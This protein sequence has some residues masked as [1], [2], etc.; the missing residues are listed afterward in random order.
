M[1][2]EPVPIQPS[3]FPTIWKSKNPT[4]LSAD[5]ALPTARRPL[6]R[7]GMMW[8]AINGIHGEL[9]NDDKVTVAVVAPAVRAA[10][11]EEFGLS[12]EFATD[13]RFVS[14]LKSV[15]FDYVFDVDFAADLTIMEESNELLARLQQPDKY[16]WPMFTSCCPAGSAL[17]RASIRSFCRSFPLPSPRSRCSVLSSKLIL[18]R[19]KA[20]H[21][22]ISPVFPSCRVCPRSAN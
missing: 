4:V 17:Q 10:W 3:M 7:S 11:G 16:S 13:R 20:L 12:P 21:R 5:S 6:S 15:G 19:K 8:E 22:K 1:C 2:P 9:A 14:T 18:H